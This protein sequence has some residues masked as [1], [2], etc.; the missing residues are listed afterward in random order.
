MRQHAADVRRGTERSARFSDYPAVIKALLVV[1]SVAQAWCRGAQSNRA[2][3]TT[4]PVSGA[5][6]PGGPCKHGRAQ[7]LT[8]DASAA[9]GSAVVGQGAIKRQP[10]VCC[11]VQTTVSQVWAGTAPGCAGLAST[12]AWLPEPVAPIY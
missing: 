9:S 7:C 3:R 8:A 6:Q 5:G 1:T 12:A 4:A 10:P 11:C 2:K